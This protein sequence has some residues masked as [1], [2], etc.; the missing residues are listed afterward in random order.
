MAQARVDM[1]WLSLAF[2]KLLYFR[3]FQHM[4]TLRC[5]QVSINKDA[6]TLALRVRRP[7]S[8]ELREQQ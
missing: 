8:Q 5:F 2:M 7:E 3:V 4:M 6:L 1:F